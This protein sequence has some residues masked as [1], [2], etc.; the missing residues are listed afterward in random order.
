MELTGCHPV[1]KEL[2]NEIDHFASQTGRFKATQE[3]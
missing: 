1:V 3:S 2:A